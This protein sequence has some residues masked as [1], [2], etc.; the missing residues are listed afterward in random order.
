VVESED[1]SV[2]TPFFRVPS[3]KGGL[4]RFE[5]AAAVKGVP[6]LRRGIE[7]V[8][9]AKSV[10]VFGIPGQVGRAAV[11]LWQEIRSAR[12]ARVEFKIWPFEEPDLSSALRRSQIT[13][14]EIYPR[15]AY[16]TALSSSLPAKAKAI[17]KTKD[18]ARRSAIEGLD[19]STWFRDVTMST[20]DRALALGSEDEFD[21]MM[22]AAALLRLVRTNTKLHLS[23]PDAR[24]EGGI[25][26]G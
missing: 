5:A 8:T 12:K 4:K 14:A 25:L 17:S 9:H 26:C 19:A 2:D 3:G 11:A 6:E 15:A 7:R 16:G 18:S 10:F 24:A 21:A 22:T 1:W 13:I 20:A 23:A